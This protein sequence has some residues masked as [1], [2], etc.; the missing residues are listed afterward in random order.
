MHSERGTRCSLIRLLVYKTD[1]CIYKKIAFG[2]KSTSRLGSNHV[3]K[4]IENPL[5]PCARVVHFDKVLELVR[6]ESLIS[7]CYKPSFL[8][9]FGVLQVQPLRCISSFTSLVGLGDPTRPSD[10]TILRLHASYGYKSPLVSQR[11]DDAAIVISRSWSAD[12]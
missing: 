4:L 3:I 5:P 2:S 6:F 12:A 10:A 9:T 1:D 11:K 7:R 8:I